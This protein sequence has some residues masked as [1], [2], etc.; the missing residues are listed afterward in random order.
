MPNTDLDYFD[1]AKKLT[2][3]HPEALGDVY[4]KNTELG[5]AREVVRSLVDQ[6]IHMAQIV[7]EVYHRD[8]AERWTECKLLF[9]KDAA[10]LLASLSGTPAKS[11][12][13][14]PLGAVTLSESDHNAMQRDADRI[15]NEIR[16]FGRELK[17]K[18]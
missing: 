16:D 14:Y 3:A 17:G 7:H 4:L 18:P 10:R 15:R 11:F 9:C 5:I 13:R 8:Q 12:E 2:A 1:I 6:I